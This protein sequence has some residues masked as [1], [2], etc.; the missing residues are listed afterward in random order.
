MPVIYIAHYNRWLG[1]ESKPEEITSLLKWLDH[2]IKIRSEAQEEGQGQKE[3][4][5]LHHA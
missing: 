2:E 3:A 4:L 5:G 1:S